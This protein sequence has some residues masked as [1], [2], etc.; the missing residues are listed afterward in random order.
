MMMTSPTLNF[1]RKSTP[2]RPGAVQPTDAGLVPILPGNVRPF[3]TNHSPAFKD[4]KSLRKAADSPQEGRAMR[5][6]EKI[7]AGGDYPREADSSA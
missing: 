3:Y 7:V 1:I 6:Y 5:L 4:K 2:H